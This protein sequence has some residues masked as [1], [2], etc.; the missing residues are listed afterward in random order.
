MVILPAE[1]VLELDSC[2]AVA[3]ASPDVSVIFFSDRLSSAERTLLRPHLTRA[4]THSGC[5]ALGVVVPR[6]SAEQMSTTRIDP[7][8]LALEP[9]DAPVRLGRLLAGP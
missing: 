4:I 6:G 5:G 9:V 3:V 2:D 8:E 1:R 7:W